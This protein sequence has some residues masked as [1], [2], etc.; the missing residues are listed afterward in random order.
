[1]I[2]RPFSVDGHP[3]DTPAALKAADL[4]E[5]AISTRSRVH[6]LWRWRSGWRLPSV[7]AAGGVHYRTVQQGVR[8][9][10][11]GGLRAVVSHRK[12]G[13]GHRPYLSEAAQR[14]VVKA[15]ATGRF[16][17]AAEIR[18]WTAAQHA[19]GY[20]MGGTYR[21]LDRL[22]GVLRSS[23]VQCR[24]KLPRNSSSPRKRGAWPRVQPGWRER[25]APRWLRR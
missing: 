19:G 20:A 16:R 13:R 23:P 24:S 12:G 11:E 10:R 6:R 18:D 17:T 9:D 4:A 2:G 5:R 21:L 15:V 8:W 3:Q 7:A 14:S 22:G 1:M 25:A